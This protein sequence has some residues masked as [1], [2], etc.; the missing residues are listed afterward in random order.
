ML[1]IWDKIIE[2]IKLD[3]FR[4]DKGPRQCRIFYKGELVIIAK[5][6]TGLYSLIHD[7]LERPK[8]QS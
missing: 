3:Y 8:D 5:E 4:V 7:L 1:T 2:H 6:D